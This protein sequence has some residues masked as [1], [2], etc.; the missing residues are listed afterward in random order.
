MNNLPIAIGGSAANPATIGH[1]YLMKW[2][3]DS[4]KFST[5]IWIL[6][7]GRPDK[8]D[9]IDS[10]HRVALTLLTFPQEWFLRRD[11]RFIISFEDVYGEN[12]PTIEWLRKTQKIYPDNMLVWYTGVDSVAPMSQYDNMSEIEYSWNSGKELF[13]NWDFLVFPRD[14]FAHPK[15]L[16]LPENFEIAESTLPDVSSSE[17]RRRISAG[18][19]FDDLMMPNAVQYVK[20]NGLYGYKM[21]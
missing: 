19:N 4:G 20:Q 17:V 9:L 7:G 12:T 11:V 5:V 10:D 2:L 21:M 1:Y 15:S 3:L 18:E 16:S 6:S 14:G 13:K 8:K